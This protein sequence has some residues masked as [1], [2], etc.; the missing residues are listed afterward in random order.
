MR[1]MR[2]REIPHIKTVIQ[3]TNTVR[4]IAGLER[5]TLVIHRL[6]TSRKW[7]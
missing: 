6:R 5:I 3:E 1:M 7:D 4:S 2:N